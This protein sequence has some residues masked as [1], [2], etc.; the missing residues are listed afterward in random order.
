MMQVLL[1]LG[2][3]PHIVDNEGVSP[4]MHISNA[5]CVRLLPEAAPDLILVRDLKGRTALMHLSYCDRR[6]HVLKELLLYCKEHRLDACV[7]SKDINGDTA[8][9]IAMVARNVRAVKL[10]LNAGSN[11]ICSGCEGT[12]ALMKPFVDEDVVSSAYAG[13]PLNPYIRATAK[14]KDAES[15]VCL[16]ALLNAV[17]LCGDSCESNVCATSDHNHRT[18]L[19]ESN[20]PVTGRWCSRSDHSAM[21]KMSAFAVAIIAY[22]LGYAWHC[23]LHSGQQ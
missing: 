19:S 12:T 18:R 7:N 20:A 8:L 14:K 21:G 6:H 13:I 9:H 17:F 2:A 3:D 1:Q 16:K 4:L 5:A 22:A 11:V 10:L 23:R 15:D